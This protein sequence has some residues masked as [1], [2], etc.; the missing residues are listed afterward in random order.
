MS[1]LTYWPRRAPGLPPG[2]RRLNIFPRF[3]DKPNRPP[4][5]Q[6]ATTIAVT[7][8]RT[9][10]RVDRDDLEALPEVC[11]RTDFHCVTTWSHQGVEWRGVLVADFWQRLVVPAVGR[12]ADAP[13]VVVCGADGHRAVFRRED[14]LAPDVLLATALNGEPL[15]ARHG[16]PLRL[17]CPSLYG[18]KSVKHV[19]GFELHNERPR[20]TL[21]AKEHLRA[22]VALEERHSRVP[23]WLL[24]WPYRLAIPLT[25]RIAERSLRR[26]R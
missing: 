17:V 22:R 19:C 2:Q 25:V 14:L 20:S 16:A 12:S 1:A 11:R 7:A 4:P 6:Q 9:S 24:R 18:Y 23:G 21:G 5:S 10:A 15:D 3:A 26:V 8:G 13:F